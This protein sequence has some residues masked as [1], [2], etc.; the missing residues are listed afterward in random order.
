MSTTA[1]SPS[2]VCR[3]PFVFSEERGSEKEMHVDWKK[4]GYGARLLL[5]TAVTS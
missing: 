3:D 5:L 4:R 1:R 2:G